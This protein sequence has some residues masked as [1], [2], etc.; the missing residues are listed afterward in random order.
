MGNPATVN[1][2]RNKTPLSLWSG[3]L[4][5]CLVTDPARLEWIFTT[6]PLSNQG[7]PLLFAPPTS[8]RKKKHRDA[9]RP[10]DE[11]IPESERKDEVEAEAA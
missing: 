10:S 11:E 5:D 2:M 4:A 8:S 3:V 1:P 7:R 6:Y 9:P